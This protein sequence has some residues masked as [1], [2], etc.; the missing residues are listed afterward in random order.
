MI[1]RTNAHKTSGGGGTEFYLN[2]SVTTG[3]LVTVTDGTTTLTGTSVAGVCSFTLPNIGTW[4]ASATL[5][6]QT[7]DTKTV[8]VIDT[9]SATLT[10]YSATLTVTAP[11]GA[12]VSVIIGSTT[13]TATSTGTATFTLTQTGTY[14]ISESLN[15][16]SNS[17]TLSVT[18]GT[19]TYAVTLYSAV[20]TV[21]SVSRVALTIAKS[22]YSQGVTSTGSN[23]FTVIETGTYTI[24][25][26]QNN[27]TYST[28]VSVVAGT[29]TYSVTMFYATVS[30]TAPSG[31]SVTFSKGAYSQSYTSTGASVS[32]TVIETGT[33]TASAALSGQ[34]TSGTA[35]VCLYYRVQ[36]QLRKRGL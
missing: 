2:I 19:T 29:T 16:Q 21:T 5:N 18:S 34:S 11:A 32:Y 26:S 28:T 23:S 24:T 12:L 15:N 10:F 4:T 8:T 9:Y 17:T 36:S 30:I 35:S 31:A 25:E 22:P 1:G 20:I 3:A 6:G 7:S 27:Q 13:Q 33:Y 14:T